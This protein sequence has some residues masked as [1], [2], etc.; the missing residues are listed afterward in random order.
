MSDFDENGNADENVIINTGVT[1]KKLEV[2]ETLIEGLNISIQNIGPIL[3][4]LLL[5]ILTILVPYINV[6]TTIGLYTGIVAKLSRGET[7]SFTEIFNP[8]YRKYMGEYFI[9][10]GLVFIGVFIGV[11]FLIIPGIII[12]LAW[13]FAPLLVIDKGKNPTEAITLSND[14]TYGY[15]GRMFLITFIISLISSTVQTVLARFDNSF[16]TFLL[17][18]VAIFQI[19]VSLS[20]QASMYK[21]L[22]GNV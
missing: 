5:W 20:I 12:S 4:N 11:I 2:G 7:I 16:A 8:K 9:T 14:I 10:I 21:Q 3:V 19:I 15:K 6:G 1:V 18:I 13:S 22:A 17:V